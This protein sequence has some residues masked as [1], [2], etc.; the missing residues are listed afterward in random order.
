M[1]NR[2]DAPSTIDRTAVAMTEL[3][4]QI[5]TLHSKCSQCGC[6][7]IGK[8]F[9]DFVGEHVNADGIPKK[10]KVTI[11]NLRRKRPFIMLIT[12]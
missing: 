7:R 4:R 12:P 2:T 11:A 8:R 9:V 5:L 10:T 1:I 6:K 3:S